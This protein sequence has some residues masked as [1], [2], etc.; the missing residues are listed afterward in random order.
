MPATRRDAGRRRPWPRVHARFSRAARGG[1]QTRAAPILYIIACGRPPRGSA[2]PPR[3]WRKVLYCTVTACT[4]SGAIAMNVQARRCRSCPETAAVL[5]RHHGLCVA[6]SRGR[7]FGGIVQAG[8]LC[9]N[10]LD[11]S[12]QVGSAMRFVTSHQRLSA[13][14]LYTPSFADLC[15]N[16]FRSLGNLKA[17]FDA[18]C[19]PSTSR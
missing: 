16:T 4:V 12:P 1:G 15:L 17:L 19:S 18:Y 13:T 8:A 9:D 5:L 6:V 11:V 3:L 2:S 14:A 10:K 7:S